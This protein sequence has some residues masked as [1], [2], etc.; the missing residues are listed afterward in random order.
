MNWKKLT[1]GITIVN[2]FAWGMLELFSYRYA[3]TNI[4]VGAGLLVA[5][6]IIGYYIISI[7]SVVPPPPV[8]E[9]EV[10]ITPQNCKDHDWQKHKYSDRQ[11]QCVRC[12]AE[13]GA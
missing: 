11:Q 5:I 2:A 1:I 10:K 9:E 8:K 3:G 12:G 4:E 7:A 13:R 6:H